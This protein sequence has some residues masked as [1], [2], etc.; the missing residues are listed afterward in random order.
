MLGEG[1]RIHLQRARW[2]FPLD[3]FTVDD[4]NITIFS[5]GLF[6]LALRLTIGAIA[7]SQNSS[8]GIELCSCTT[9]KIALHHAFL[10]VLRN[11]CMFFFLNK[12]I[13][14]SS[15]L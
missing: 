2:F 15:A 3:Y 1:E 8:L 10:T 12:K 14:R 9:I 13:R 7:Y 4:T 5:F 6:L 11:V